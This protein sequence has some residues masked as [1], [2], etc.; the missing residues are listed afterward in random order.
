MN[1]SR[2]LLGPPE[3]LG[4]DHDDAPAL[5]LESFP[6]FPIALPLS[7][8]ALVLPAVILDQNPEAS[9]DEISAGNESAVF[10]ADVDVDF[11]NRQSRELHHQPHIGFPRRFDAFPDVGKCAP[12]SANSIE[13]RIHGEIGQLFTRRQSE[14][15][16]P[17]PGSDEFDEG[18]LRGTVDEGSVWTEYGDPIDNVG[19]EP[20]LSTMKDDTRESASKGRVGR[21]LQRPFLA[22]GDLPTLEIARMA[23]RSIGR[24]GKNCGAGTDVLGDYDIVSDIDAAKQPANPL[25]PQ[26]LWRHAGSDRLGIRERSGPNR[27]G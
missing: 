2:N 16:H 26:R 19:V 27:V 7:R 22:H 4:C 9:V 8:I 3:V 14:T 24:K 11:G 25:A 15:Y 5:C 10:V 20:A 17:I 1:T 12:G 6:S 18:Q 13:V 21:K 23:Q